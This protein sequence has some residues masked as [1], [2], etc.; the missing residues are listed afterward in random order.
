MFVLKKQL[1]LNNNIEFWKSIGKVGVAHS[2]K[3]NIPVEVV[4]EDESISRGSYVVLEKWR[5]CFYNFYNPQA[6]T[7]Q[8]QQEHAI[9]NENVNA[10]QHT[11]DDVREF[12]NAIS[13]DEVRRAVYSANRGKAC[14]FDQMCAEVFKNDTAISF[15]HVLFNVCFNTGNIP[16][17]WGKGVIN[18]IPKSGTT[19]PRDPLSYRGITLA[20][21]MCKLY[22]T[23]ISAPCSQRNLR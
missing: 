2:K 12:N 17:D 21:V 3:N 20:P 19:D 8:T 22:C 9:Y 23:V 18:P 5:S 13:T 4:L 15:L 11:Q 6:I 16:T 10:A 1:Y 7:Q 14:G